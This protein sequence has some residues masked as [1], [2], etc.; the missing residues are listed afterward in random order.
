MFS[1]ALEP[2]SAE[3]LA[4][5]KFCECAKD[6]CLD[7]QSQLHDFR[8]AYAALHQDQDQQLL[9]DYMM[10]MQHLDAAAEGLFRIARR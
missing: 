3:T 2:R 6:Y 5:I 4:E 1:T 10:T 8:C 9:A 7:L